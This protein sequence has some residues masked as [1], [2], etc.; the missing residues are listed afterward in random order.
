MSGTEAERRARRIFEANMNPVD[1]GYS[2]QRLVFLPELLVAGR[3]DSFDSPGRDHSR[4][5]IGKLVEGCAAARACSYTPRRR[6]LDVTRAQQQ[7]MPRGLGV[8]G[9]LTQG[10]AI[11]RIVFI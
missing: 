8:F 2:A 4:R 11:S 3:D 10:S 7:G 9:R 6:V 5:T 1:S